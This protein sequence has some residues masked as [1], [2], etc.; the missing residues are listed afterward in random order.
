MTDQDV[1]NEMYDYHDNLLACA[2]N[3][4]KEEVDA[5]DIVSETYMRAINSI[6]TFENGTNLK[7]WLLAIC[8]NQAINLY[9][10]NRRYSEGRDKFK[11]HQDCTF[12]IEGVDEDAEEILQA[13]LGLP[14]P[15]KAA[16][17]LYHYMHLSYK[18]IGHRLGIPI[19]TVMSKLH[20]GR[21][22]LAEDEGLQL[23]AE[24]RGN[25]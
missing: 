21:K 18:E 14:E 3:W 2:R 6:H 17:F 22:I 12:Y 15:F 5:E 19:G 23:L 4:S 24:R 25:A 16:M 7:G 20:R 11:Y 9:H 1:I 10:K 13:V 8:R